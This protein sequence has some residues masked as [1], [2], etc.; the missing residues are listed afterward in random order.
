MTPRKMFDI[1]GLDLFFKV[2]IVSTVMLK[3]G[4]VYANIVTVYMD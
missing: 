1:F 3:K 2:E 4:K